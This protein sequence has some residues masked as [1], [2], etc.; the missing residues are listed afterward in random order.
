MPVRSHPQTHIRCSAPPGMESFDIIRTDNRILP[1]GRPIFPVC[2]QQ[3]FPRQQI[4]QIVYRT[5]LLHPPLIVCR[6]CLLCLQNRL[7]ARYP[8]SFRGRNHRVG[9][10][11][12]SP[13]PA[14]SGSS[15][16]LSVRDD[17]LYS[18][19]PAASSPVGQKI[20]SSGAVWRLRRYFLM[21]SFALVLRSRSPYVINSLQAVRASSSRSVL[22][23]G[24]PV[25]SCV[26]SV[27]FLPCPGTHRRYMLP[28]CGGS[29]S[30]TALLRPPDSINTQIPA[31]F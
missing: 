24:F 12:C 21:H 31:S 5:S 19:R 15:C 4:I 16:P 29:S 8:V 3:C 22:L 28:T 30:E 17:C 18:H 23:Y 10:A 7:T 11:V 14:L 2:G 25:V 20:R 1:H 6:K 13:S 26:I 27:P 9:C